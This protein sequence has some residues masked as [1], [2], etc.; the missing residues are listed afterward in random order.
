MVGLAVGLLF[1]DA[2]LALGGGFGKQI[3]QTGNLLFNGFLGQGAVERIVAPSL[4]GN[5]QLELQRLTDGVFG[6]QVGSDG[7]RLGD[8]AALLEVLLED[9]L[10][11]QRRDF[12]GFVDV[13][14]VACHIE[15]DEIVGIELGEGFGIGDARLPNLGVALKLVDR[16]GNLLKGLDLVLDVGEQSRGLQQDVHGVLDRQRVIIRL[17]LI[18][19]LRIA[20]NRRIERIDLV[21][22]LVDA[23]D[24]VHHRRGLVGG[25]LD[26]LSRGHE[27]AQQFQHGVRRERRAGNRIPACE[28]LVQLA[29]DDRVVLRDMG[30]AEHAEGVGRMHDRVS[31]AGIHSQHAAVKRTHGQ[32]AGSLVFRLLALGNRVRAEEVVRGGRGQTAPVLAVVALRIAVPHEVNGRCVRMVRVVEG[33]VVRCLQAFHRTVAVERQDIPGHAAVDVIREGT[34]LG[35]HG[36][37]LNLDRVSTRIEVVKNAGRVV[38]DGEVEALGSVGADVAAVLDD[39]EERDGAVHDGIGQVRDVL[40]LLLGLCAGIGIVALE[41]KDAFKR[42]AVDVLE[43]HVHLRLHQLKRLDAAVELKQERH[44]TAAGIDIGLKLERAF[45][46]L[47]KEAAAD[48]AFRVGGSERIL[49][50]LVQGGDVKQVAAQGIGDVLRIAKV[51]LQL[52]QQVAQRLKCVGDVG[53]DALADQLH[54][55]GVLLGQLILAYG[56]QQIA[57]GGE[58]RL[59]SLVAAKQRRLEEVLIGV[60]AN[61]LRLADAAVKVVAHTLGA[62]GVIAERHAQADGIVLEVL[63]QAVGTVLRIGH[64]ALAQLGEVVPHGLA[65]VLR[66]FTRDGCDGI[67]LPLVKLL[68]R[69]RIE[70]AHAFHQRVVPR[71][72]I[73][74][75]LGEGSGLGEVLI[76]QREG[77]HRDLTKALGGLAVAQQLVVGHELA[78]LVARGHEGLVKEHAF[79]EEDLLL[80]DALG[81]R[82]DRTITVVERQE[83]L[84][85]A[86]MLL[87]IEVVFVAEEGELRGAA[88][89]G[90]GFFIR[91]IVQ[92]GFGDGALHELVGAGEGLTLNIAAAHE[93]HMIIRLLPGDTLAVGVFH[94]ILGMMT[95]IVHPEVEFL[96]RGVAVALDDLD[97]G[98]GAAFFDDMLDGEIRHDDVAGEVIGEVLQTGRVLDDI[99]DDLAHIKERTGAGA[100]ADAGDDDDLRGACSALTAGFRVTQLRQGIFD[101]S[102]DGVGAFIEHQAGSGAIGAGAGAALRTDLMQIA[103]HPALLARGELVVIR[104]DQLGAEID[105]FRDVDDFVVIK[106]VF[107]GDVAV[108]NEIAG[109]ARDGDHLAV[110]GYGQ[111]EAL[112]KGSLDRAHGVG[113]GAAKADDEQRRIEFLNTLVGDIQ[114]FVLP[115]LGSEVFGCHINHLPE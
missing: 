36:H 39:A 84:G 86:G 72:E 70:A 24:G 28:Q 103:V 10:L 114:L 26:R 97:H 31:D 29:L 111:V 47:A 79:V 58:I 69:G 20:G 89:R 33:G 85:E 71:A 6:R 96:E 11:D 35:R 9:G 45:A 65:V 55:M 51:G 23:H 90:V 21:Q 106:T 59:H 50:V 76:E 53:I 75:G 16:L 92:Q 38:G 43:A 105:V 77:L 100:A 22:V 80:G 40:L 27:T 115:D 83:H 104:I 61:L 112:G 88:N 62:G 7:D 67:L 91:H 81:I 74:E 18:I 101:A 98:R 1:G 8:L 49:N 110:R 34:G 13:D 102:E 78:V 17:R 30:I 52:L 12:A 108:K 57:Q 93:G 37:A 113:A 32:L 14:G 109:A 82:A 54:H 68:V 46:Q 60:D 87:R 3:S 25:M 19:Q 64:D 2:G 56:V 5:T 48:S 73:L 66:K 63:Q 99:A 94:L 15:V 107:A 4:F 42:H 44:A 95:L 41:L